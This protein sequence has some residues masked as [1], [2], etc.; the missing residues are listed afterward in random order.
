MIK[1]INNGSFDELAPNGNAKRLIYHKFTGHDRPEYGMIG[2]TAAQVSDMAPENYAFVNQGNTEPKSPK[3][4]APPAQVEYRTF[5]DL[6]N[7]HQK[8]LA[9]P[10]EISLVNTPPV[11]NDEVPI[12]SLVPP[13][14]PV[15]GNVLNL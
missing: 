10:K 14:V 15:L 6:R 2:S 4:Q 5:S 1:N 7:E 12:A 3:G 13:P 9:A 8:T 11:S